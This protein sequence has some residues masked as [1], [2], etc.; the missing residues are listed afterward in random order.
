M[1][2]LSP[3][4]LT[5]PRVHIGAYTHVNASDIVF[6][7]GES[8]YSHVHFANNSKGCIVA[9]TLRILETRLAERG[10]VRVNRSVLINPDY[11]RSYDKNKIELT[12]GRQFPIARRR[13]TAVRSHLARLQ[14]TVVTA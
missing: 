5:L 2:T 3:T 9:C 14:T 7:T 8:N 4:N 1:S 12:N 13:R 11:I 10:F 6:V